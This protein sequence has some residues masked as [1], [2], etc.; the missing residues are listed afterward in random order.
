MRHHHSSVGFVWSGASL[1]C[2]LTVGAALVV[3]QQSDTTRNPLGSSPAA[4]AAGRAVFDQTCQACHGPGATGDRGPALNTGAFSRG[5]E[6][7]DLF[8]T[9]REGLPGTQMPPFSGLTDQQVWQ[10]V[11]YLRSLSGIGGDQSA[12]SRGPTRGN[13]AAGETLF[14]GRAACSSCHQVNGRG[15]VVGP[16]LSTI[17]RAPADLIRQKILNPSL[18]M[19]MPGAGGRGGGGAGAVAAA[20][21]VVIVAKT[22]DGREIQGVRRNEDTF[23][24]QM[25]DATGTL[26]LLDKLQLTDFRIENRSLMPGDFGTKLTANDIDDVVAYLATLRERDLTAASSASISGGRRKPGRIR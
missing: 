20:R 2:A 17:A 5:S 13:P 6:D 14:F 11:S 9:I 8:H 24:V 15:A 12:A 23:S 16:D 21:P 7:G 18:P 25:V 3:A 4:V 10:V 22:R 19:V 1:V 26:H